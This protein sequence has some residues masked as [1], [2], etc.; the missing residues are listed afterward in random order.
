MNAASTSSRRGLLYVAIAVFFFSTSPI[1]IR[2][3]GTLSSYE[4]AAGRLAVAAMAL[5]GLMRIRREQWAVRREDRSKFALFGLITALHFLFYIASLSFTS[6]AHSLAIVYTAPIF[7]A[8]FSAIFLKEPI[9]RRR[10]LGIFITVAGIAALTGFQPQFDTRMLIGDLLA[11]GS[12]ITFGLYSIAGRSQRHRYSLLT[13]AVTVYAVAALWMAIPAAASFTPEGYTWLAVLSIIGLGILPMGLGHTLYNAALR[14]TNAT[15]VNVIATQEVTGG[16]ILG[17]ILLGE[18][19][20]INEIV[21]VII[22][23]IGI[24]LVIL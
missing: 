20:T 9:L 18:I 6:I 1:F 10:W 12:A 11:L 3:A 7:V 24:V 13:Y 17:V 5:A 8:I 2:W 21:G 22:T 23:L 4:I 15:Y 19:P 16:I 14:H